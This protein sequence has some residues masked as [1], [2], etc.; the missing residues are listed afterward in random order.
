VCILHLYMS[1]YIYKYIYKINSQKKK[2]LVRYRHPYRH[3]KDKGKHLQLA[4]MIEYPSSVLDT[5][6]RFGVPFSRAL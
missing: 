4:R 3:V 5:S 2:R 6:N 1:I